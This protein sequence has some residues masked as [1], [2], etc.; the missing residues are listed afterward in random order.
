ME[1]VGLKLAAPQVLIPVLLVVGVG[2]LVWLVVLIVKGTGGKPAGIAALGDLAHSPILQLVL[3]GVAQRAHDSG[4]AVL[5]AAIDHM[6][7]AVAPLLNPAVNQLADM[8]DEKIMSGAPAAPA[9]PPAPLSAADVAAK[10]QEL[11]TMLANLKTLVH[12]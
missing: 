7:P 3:K 1:A 6:F 5:D 4:H 12:G 2:A 9:S 10:L 8:V 11:E